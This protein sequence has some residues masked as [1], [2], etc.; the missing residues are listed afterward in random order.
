[1]VKKYA[2]AAGIP[3]L[4]WGNPLLMVIWAEKQK[5]MPLNSM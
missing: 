1:M 5:T 3:S 4:K 2:M